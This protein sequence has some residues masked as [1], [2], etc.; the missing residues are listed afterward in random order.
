MTEFQTNGFVLIKDFLDSQ[1]VKTLS[2]YLLNCSKQNHFGVEDTPYTKTLSKY[3]D[4]VI[5]VVLEQS[6][7]EVERFTGMQLY[8]TYSF[9][10]IYTGGTYMRPH[11]DRDA[12]EVSLTV[13]VA[14]Q[15]TPCPIWMRA[16]GK[17]PVCYTLS[18]GDAVLYKG[19][20]IEHWRDAMPD[21]NVVV[22]F[23][24]HYVDKT[25]P[26]A[27][28]KF[29]KRPELGMHSGVGGM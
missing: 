29:N 1:S 8:P 5:E 7:A 12:C 16:L 24:L 6:L 22:Q 10:R 13:N 15:G 26:H 11:V 18:P 20:E 3:A 21:G 2:K 4:P 25:G 27:G 19:C 23:M 9:A 28:H 14:T 17:T